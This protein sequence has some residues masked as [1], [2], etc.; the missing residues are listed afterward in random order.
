MQRYD[1]RLCLVL[2][3]DR[4][5]FLTRMC[6]LLAKS[7]LANKLKLCVIR[8]VILRSISSE[9]TVFRCLSAPD[10][11]CPTPLCFIHHIVAFGRFRKDSSLLYA[12]A[13]SSGD[14]QSRAM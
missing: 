10:L 8:Y 6:A 5:P 2:L 3:K 1:L 9:L 12:V 4:V 11:L 14:Q 7:C 13:L